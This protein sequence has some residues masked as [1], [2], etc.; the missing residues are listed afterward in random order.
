MIEPVNPI[1][2]EDQPARFVISISLEFGLAA[3]F[4]IIN[5]YAVHAW[6]RIAESRISLEPHKT[7][8]GSD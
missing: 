8:Q 4:S 2:N 6:M 1:L 3:L 5:E 7:N